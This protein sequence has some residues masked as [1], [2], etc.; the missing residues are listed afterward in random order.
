M[1]K[2]AGHS[3]AMGNAI[4]EIKSI[5]DEITDTTD[6]DGVAIVLERTFS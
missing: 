4:D 1:M 3:V 2:F 6:N 5:S